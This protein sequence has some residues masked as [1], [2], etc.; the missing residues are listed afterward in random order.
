MTVR[1]LMMGC[2]AGLMLGIAQS[3]A[4]VAFGAGTRNVFSLAILL[5]FLLLRPQGLLGQSE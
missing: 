4:T 5:I 3:L 1:S 2:V